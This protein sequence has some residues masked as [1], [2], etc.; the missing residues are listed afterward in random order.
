MLYDIKVYSTLYECC[1]VRHVEDR[2]NGGL[3]S[4]HLT[5]ETP[6]FIREKVYD[7]QNQNDKLYSMET[8]FLDI[9]R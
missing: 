3:C 7:Q 9:S 2:P 6:L 8:A 1:H 5:T 4:H